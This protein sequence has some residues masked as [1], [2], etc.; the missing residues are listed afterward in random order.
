MQLVISKNRV[1]EV[2]Q[3]LRDV[4]DLRVKKTLAK[5][6]E[7]FYLKK[8]GAKFMQSEMGHSNEERHQ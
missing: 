7:R 3:Q 2:L 4:G 6:R 1:S 5:I 8:D